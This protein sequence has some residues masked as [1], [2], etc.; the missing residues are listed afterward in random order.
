MAVITERVILS[1]RETGISKL[2]RDVKQSLL[3]PTL[4]TETGRSWKRRQ[5][6]LDNLVAGIIMGCRSPTIVLSQLRWPHG[7]LKDFLL[8]RNSTWE[9]IVPACAE[10][11][12]ERETRRSLAEVSRR[13][14]IAQAL[15]SYQSDQDTGNHEPTSQIPSFRNRRTSTHQPALAN[16]A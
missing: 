10:R 1:C 8:L 7:N 6:I 11:K 4:I 14:R 5:R 9:S 13:R 2:G 15:A 3:R 12:P 16:A